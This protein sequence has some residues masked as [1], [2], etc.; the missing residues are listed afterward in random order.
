MRAPCFALALPP[1]LPANPAGRW[2]PVDPHKVLTLTTPDGRAHACWDRCYRLPAE[3]VTF[4]CI[5]LPRMTC[6]EAPGAKGA[7]D[8]CHGPA[9]ARI[10]LPGQA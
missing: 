1:V 8:G 5:I 3:R 6:L 7:L 4:R 9:A 2:W 10:C